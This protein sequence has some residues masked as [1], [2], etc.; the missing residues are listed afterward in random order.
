MK[1]DINW[2]ELDGAINPAPVR[3]LEFTR[4]ASQ[5]RKVAFD[6]YEK[7]GE[8]G[9][10]ELQEKEDG[11]RV[12][13]ALY[14]EDLPKTATASLSKWSA[15][16]SRSGDSVTLQYEGTPVAK[17]NADAFGFEPK[18]AGRFATFIAVQ[19]ERGGAGF[20]QRLASSLS[21][22]AKAHLLSTVPV[23]GE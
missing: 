9:L 2:N 18:E 15:L 19:A 22:G 23:K 16:A 13:V 3:E 7:I 20:V 4:V 5:F 1:F 14:E 10:W 12:L 8:T 17:L 11:S 21:T 6:V